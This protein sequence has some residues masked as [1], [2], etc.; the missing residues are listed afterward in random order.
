[1]DQDAK[2]LAPSNSKATDFNTASVV[3]DARTGEYYYGMNKG[4]KLSGDKIEKTLSDIL[5][6]K[7]LNN[8]EVGN[9]AE[10]DAVNQALKKG[11]NL[12]DLYIYTIDARTDKYGVPKLGFGTPKKACKN[13]TFTFKGKVGDIISGFFDD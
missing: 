13:C 3:Y 10:V 8:Y 7:S 9:C 2:K 5:P 12:S 6:T 1:M 4:V 11:A